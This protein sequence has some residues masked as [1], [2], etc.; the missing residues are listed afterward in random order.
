M[1]KFRMLCPNEPDAIQLEPNGCQKSKC[2]AAHAAKTAETSRGM[3]TR[4]VGSL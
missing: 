2:A 4:T 3:E 1:I